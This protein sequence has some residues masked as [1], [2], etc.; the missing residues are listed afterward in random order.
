VG[1]K[2]KIFK[3]NRYLIAFIILG[4]IAA[5]IVDVQRYYV[6]KNNMTVDLAIDYEDLMTLAETEGQPVEKVLLQA[7]DAGL[8]SLAV[9][10]TTFKKLNANGKVSATPG[11]EILQQYHNGSLTNP[12]WQEL[13]TNGKIVGTKVY[14]TGNDPQTFREVK[15]DLMRRFGADRVTSM[16]VGREEVLELKA[17]YEAL[18]KMNL[19]MPTDEMKAV[20]AAGF[21]VIARPS[22]YSF[23]TKE[24]VESVFKRLEGIKVSEMIFS[25]AEVLG[26]PKEINVTVQ[27]LK[28]KD[29]TLG[30]IEATTQLQFYKQD[31]LMELAKGL[32]YKAARLY[33]IPKDEQPKLKQSVAIE[34]WANTDE[35][36]NIRVDLLRIYE[37]PAPGMTLLQTNMKYISATRDI[38]QS[39]GFTLDRAGTFTGFY[40]GSTLRMIMMLGVA[41]AAV[42]YLS[43]IFP[44]FKPKYQ[45]ILFVLL[46][47]AAVVPLAMGNG[48]KVR[49]LAALASANLFPALAV[50]WQLDRVRELQAKPDTSLAKIIVT[51]FLALFVAG[52]ISFVG[53]AYLSGSLADV[54][55]LLE[56]NVF[57]G[58]KLTFILPLVLVSIA[59][60]QRFDIFDGAA[61]DT[62]GVMGQLKHILDIPVRIKTLLGF[63]AILVVGIVF[64]ARSGHTSGM[65]VS[66]LELRFRAFLE[67]SMYAR[68]RSK[69]LLI[70]HPAFMLAVMAWYRK[71]PTMV[72]FALVVV[73][74]IGQGSMVETFAHM[75]TPIF[76]SFVRGMG[77]IVL[78]AGIG[79]VAMVA[80]H[81]WQRI[82]SSAGG[83]KSEHE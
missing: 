81:F 6:E 23:A 72:F 7:K 8:T 52:A 38:L 51:G 32:D 20:N 3:Y 43:L 19:G 83:S 58:I 14:V 76:M 25:G 9:Y 68:P 31:G 73:A 46:A 75:R 50:I 69:E 70:G 17:N 71:W 57:R 16:Q 5:F 28:Q 42:L 1:N 34:R 37:K 55:Y 30:M 18:L 53:A 47:L 45:Y 24:D 48:A 33:A 27:E 61:D 74:T 11:S 59:F 67:Q 56:V 2:L 39:K 40:P 12:A 77:G 60:L 10:E 15:E 13:A 78:G 79:A 65:P 64:I 4:V 63:F 62:K 26:N 49:V 29:I 22:N 44:E 66:D 35:E 36:R 54:E 82:I 21:Y 80:V 41:A